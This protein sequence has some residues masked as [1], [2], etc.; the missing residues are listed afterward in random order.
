MESHQIHIDDLKNGTGDSCLVHG[1]SKVT[2]RREEIRL[3]SWGLIKINF[4]P[5]HLSLHTLPCLRVFS[6]SMQRWH[7][8]GS[9]L[10]GIKDYQQLQSKLK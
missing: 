4:S 7:W 3:T 2:S 5:P 10:N 9:C 8:K 1:V 6:L